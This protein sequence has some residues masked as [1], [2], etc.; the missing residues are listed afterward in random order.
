MMSSKHQGVV[1]SLIRTQRVFLPQSRPFS[2]STMVLRAP[3]LAE[4]ATASS[5]SRNTWSASE[6]AALAI[7][8]SLTPGTESWERR[9]RMGRLVMR[10]VLSGSRRLRA[11]ARCRRRR[12]R[13]SRSTASVS[14]PRSGRAAADAGRRPGELD[15]LAGDAHRL[16]QARAARSAPACRARRSGRRGRSR[17]CSSPART[18]RRRP[19]AACSSALVSA[20]VQRREPLDH[21]RPVGGAGLGRGERRLVAASPARPAP[22]SRARKKGSLGQARATKPSAAG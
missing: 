1:T 6:A 16:R 7:I 18:A 17:R 22:C 11:S 13:A 5:R 15:R 2:A 20:A 21:R 8:F 3:A 12:R 10:L 9:R 19:A 4:G 14:S